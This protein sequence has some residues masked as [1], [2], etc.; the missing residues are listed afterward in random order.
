MNVPSDWPS[1]GAAAAVLSLA[2]ALVAWIVRNIVR[3]SFVPTATHNQLDN[4][5]TA[6][7]HKVAAAPGH[8]EFS[9]LSSR[10]AAVE[11]GVAVVAKALE[12]VA[13]GIKR[14]EHMTD[15]LIRH[16]LREDEE[17]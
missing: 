2:I 6:L 8:A 1:L 7:E 14:I 10:V 12:G 11:T 16:Q 3:D 5:V 13:D 17:K 4:R 15:L 9:N